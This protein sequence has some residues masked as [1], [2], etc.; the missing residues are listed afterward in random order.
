MIDS[1]LNLYLNPTVAVFTCIRSVEQPMFHLMLS[2]LV[3]ASEQGKKTTQPDYY[4]SYRE[5]ALK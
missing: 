3:E 1:V 5:V 2:K 4:K